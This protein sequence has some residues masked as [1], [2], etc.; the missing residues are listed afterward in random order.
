MIVY[1]RRS[2]NARK[3]LDAILDD[4]K[5]VQFGDARYS[6]YTAHKD[7]KRMERYISRHQANED[8]SNIK[9]AGTWSRYILWNKPSLQASIEDMERRFGIDIRIITQ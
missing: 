5:I 1:L 7:E 3:K 4:G 8:W 9:K 2:S 6:D